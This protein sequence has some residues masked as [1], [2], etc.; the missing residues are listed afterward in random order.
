MTGANPSASA[1][2][3]DPLAKRA[4]PANVYA[5]SGG[6]REGPPSPRAGR[7]TAFAKAAVGF[8]PT[9]NGFAI[10]PLGPLGYAAELPGGGLTPSGTDHCRLRPSIQIRPQPWDAQAS[11]RAFS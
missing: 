10:R 11:A 4:A 3:A 7:E 9:N 8:E 5:R 1:R 2:P 6:A